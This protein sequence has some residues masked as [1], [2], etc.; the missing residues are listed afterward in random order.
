MNI[1]IFFIEKTVK[2]LKKI[3][4]KSDQ[5]EKEMIPRVWW[6]DPCNENSILTLCIYSSVMLKLFVMLILHQNLI[7]FFTF[8][9]MINNESV[10]SEL[11]ETEIN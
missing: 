8:I 9:L 5:G 6:V 10:T 11:T 7:L 2:L 1:I 4:H 3:L